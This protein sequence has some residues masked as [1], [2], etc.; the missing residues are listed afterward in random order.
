MLDRL[1]RFRFDEQGV[2]AIEYATIAGLLSMAIAVVVGEVGTEVANLFD[3]V[4]NAF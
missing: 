3:G 4:K 2:T 1:T